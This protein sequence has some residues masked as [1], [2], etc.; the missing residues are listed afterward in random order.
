MDLGEHILNESYAKKVIENEESQNFVPLDA[1]DELARDEKIPWYEDIYNFFRWRLPYKIECAW[2]NIFVRWER[3]KNGYAHSDVWNFNNY[4]AEIISNGS[5]ELARISHGRPLCVDKEE[6]W[7][8]ILMKISK[9][10]ALLNEEERGF[11][12]LTEEEEKQ[13]SEAFEL[14]KEWFEYLWD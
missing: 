13:F 1:I 4:L 7:T 8:A 9:G 3:G 10:F 11:E 6:E 5:E 14:L 12:P 2:D